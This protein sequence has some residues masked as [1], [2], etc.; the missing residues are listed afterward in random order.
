VQEKIA[1]P[2][3]ALISAGLDSGLLRQT[4]ASGC[5][6]SPLTGLRPKKP[7]GK[8]NKLLAGHL[9]LHIFGHDSEELETVVV[10]LL[11]NESRRWH[12]R[13]H[14]RRLHRKLG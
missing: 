8:R 5:A 9:G 2:L 6:A 12:W 14:A 4:G 3:Q 10:R 11:M 13:S 7:S 1:G